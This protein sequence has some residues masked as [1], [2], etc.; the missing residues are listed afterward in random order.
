MSCPA[1][2]ILGARNQSPAMTILAGP[3]GLKRTGYGKNPSNPASGPAVLIA[4][5]QLALGIHRTSQRPDQ[6]TDQNHDDHCNRNYIHVAPHPGSASWPYEPRPVFQCLPANALLSESNPKATRR[7][8]MI[9][10]RTPVIT[11]TLVR[12]DVNATNGIRNSRSPL[13]N[14]VSPPTTRAQN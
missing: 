4:V 12:I 11:S 13:P 5:R 9:S 1:W 8:Q 3:S 6:V 2:V 10:E 14:T 7:A